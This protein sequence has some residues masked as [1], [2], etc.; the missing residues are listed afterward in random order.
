M[1]FLEHISYT[2]VDAGIKY[3]KEHSLNFYMPTDEITLYHVYWYGTI[4]RHEIC[5][6]LSYLYSQDLSS[7][8]LW[9][10]L[11]KHTYDLSKNGIPKHENIKVK[12]YDPTNEATGTPFV[13]YQYLDQTT[14]IK[15]RSDIFRVLVL[16]NYGG[17]YFDLDMLLLKDL[18][19]LLGLEFCYS[20]ADLKGGNNGI[21]RLKQHSPLCIQ[22]MDKY[23][24]T[25]SPFGLEGRRFF[26][27]YNYKYIF[28]ED[29][30][31]TCLPCVLFDP[32]WILFDRKTKSIYS[33]LAN[34]DDF[35]KS[36]DEDIDNFFDGK[37]YAY[38]IHSRNNMA[39]EE[40]SYFEKFEKRFLL[41]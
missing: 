20:W 7:T 36:T 25:V 15:F 27:G 2:D 8:E 18:K 21:L 14:S 12:K 22:I 29:I 41:G 19:P 24:N 32:V 30:D 37:I 5:S 33:A 35:F 17:V 1:K 4:G 40:N 31:L 10:W 38:H 23:R 26:L 16:Y 3:L 28:T 9:V 11:D 13:D 39:V 6:I 34:F